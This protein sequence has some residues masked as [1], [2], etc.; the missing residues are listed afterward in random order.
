M[1]SDDKRSEH[2]IDSHNLLSYECLDEDG[3]VAS[4]GMGRTLDVSEKGILLET[5]APLNQNYLISLTLSLEDMLLDI[6]GKI[7]H[8]EEPEK[9]RFESGIR[10]VEMDKAKARI[11]RQFAEIFKDE[12]KES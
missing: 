6:K 7:T 8:T 3:K 11:L 1:K 12:M 4:Q 5:H 9:G 2:R 10:F